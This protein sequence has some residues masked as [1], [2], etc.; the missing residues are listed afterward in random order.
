MGPAA[1]MSCVPTKKRWD[2]LV[3]LGAA[4]A[5]GACGQ[6]TMQPMKPQSNKAQP[7]PNTSQVS[8]ASD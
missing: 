1:A 8:A 6:G 2:T 3:T 7:N 4:G 5:A